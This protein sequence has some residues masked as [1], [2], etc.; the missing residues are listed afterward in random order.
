MNSKDK[1]KYAIKVFIAFLLYYTGILYIYRIICLRK[2][3]IV[4]MY[5]RV[6]PKVL[7]EGTFSHSGIIVDDAI[8]EM[9]VRYLKKIFKVVTLEEFSRKHREGI[10]FDRPA[11]L[12]TFD[13][14]WKDNYTYAYPILKKYEMPATI[15]MPVNYIDNNIQ[16]WQEKLTGILMD[17]YF[18]GKDNTDNYQMYFDLLKKYNLQEIMSVS[19]DNIRSSVAEEVS[20]MKM[21]TY[22]EI[23]QI[24]AGLSENVEFSKGGMENCDSFLS[25]D[26]VRQMKDDGISFGSHG[27][28]H[29][30]LTNVTSSE[31][32]Y[33]IAESMKVLKNKI[34]EDISSISYPNGNYKSNII[35]MVKSH[36]YQTAFSTENGFVDMADNPYSLKRVNIHNDVTDNIPMFLCVI[37][38]VF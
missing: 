37:L 38:G 21:L 29:K 11:C 23:E 33:E 5:H 14:G 34:N 19:E 8:F 16:F 31:A 35:E 2:K 10:N 30:I 26:E 4:L 18:M 25:W 12:I 3:T 13:D 20:K 6:L 9:Q 15:F 36:G 17:M 7:R 24:I 22:K 27:M 1:I 32:E 28:N